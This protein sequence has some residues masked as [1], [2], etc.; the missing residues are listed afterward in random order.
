MIRSLEVRGK[1]I[2]SYFRP[3][4]EVI[5]WTDFSNCQGPNFH[6]RVLPP[7]DDIIINAS[8]GGQVSWLP[9]KI[10]STLVQNDPSQQPVKCEIDRLI[11]G[12][13]PGTSF[14]R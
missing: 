14:E 1:G 13:L 7:P 3:I 4:G 12:V 9:K 11:S 2:Y 6:L 8:F 10:T 5:I